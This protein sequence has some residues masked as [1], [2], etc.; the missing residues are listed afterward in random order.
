MYSVR[1]SKPPGSNTWYSSL[2]NSLQMT[3]AIT[4][5]INIGL[6]RPHTGESG[7]VV[8]HS[9]CAAVT[10][11]IFNLADLLRPAGSLQCDRQKKPNHS[12]Q[13]VCLAIRENWT[14][15]VVQQFHFCIFDSCCR[16]TDI[17]GEFFKA[18]MMSFTTIR[19]HF[20][21]HGFLHTPRS[22]PWYFQIRT[23]QSLMLCL[24][25]WELM[26]FSCWSRART[27]RV[28]SDFVQH[29]AEFCYAL[30]CRFPLG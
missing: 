11:T 9:R 15:V 2:I 10:S 8:Q 5:L 27:A 20:Q 14:R 28:P 7:L 4:T 12:P 29:G 6:P 24:V 19:L 3:E 16:S 23:C 25:D 21:T 17:P 30:W 13:V 26:H 1:E 18:S 22:L